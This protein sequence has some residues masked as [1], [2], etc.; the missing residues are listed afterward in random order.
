MA[1][2]FSYLAFA[3]TTWYG[4]IW[5]GSDDRR[6]EQHQVHASTH[7]TPTTRMFTNMHG[8]RVLPSS[9]T[10]TTTTTTRALASRAVGTATATH[11]RRMGDFVHEPEVVSHLLLQPFHG[12]SR[13]YSDAIPLTTILAPNVVHVHGSLL[14]VCSELL[15]GGR[16]QAR[17][18]FHFF[19]NLDRETCMR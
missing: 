3:T 4:L 10:T 15:F 1:S 8:C 2:S 7:H 9:A 19:R 14:E 13:L 18:L 16:F 5:C 17:Q 11:E 6:E 12:V